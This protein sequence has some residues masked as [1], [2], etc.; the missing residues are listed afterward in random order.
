M[1]SQQII[2]E[3]LVTLGLDGAKFDKGMADAEKKQDKLRKAA[4]KWDK[5][6]RQNRDEEEREERKAN[7]RRE[8]D[9]SRTYKN[10]RRDALAF[11]SVFTAG[12][13][14]HNFFSDT[15]DSAANLGYLSQNLN[16]STQELSAW[17]MATQRAGGSAEGIVA[18]FK[19][20]ADTL[21]Q[22]RLGMGP[23]EG[24]QN[25]FR[26]GGSKDDLKDA[27]SYLLARSRIINQAFQTDPAKAALMA[28]QMGVF[29]DQFNFIKQGPDAVNSLVDA[30]KKNAVVTADAAE[31]ARQ[32]KNQWLDFT[33]TLE[34]STIKVL[35]AAVP[36]L[37]KFTE[38]LVELADK[39]ANNKD[40]I[41]NVIG[42]MSKFL[43]TTDWTAVINGAKEFGVEIKSIAT[44]LRDI[45]DR[46]DEWRG[47]PRVQTEGVTN[48]PGAVSFGKQDAM[49]ADLKAKGKAPAKAP[50]L[51]GWQKS[52]V[53]SL[54]KG[55]E[56]TVDTFK[57]L[58]KS[59]HP[60]IDA[61]T[62]G[63]LNK[64][65][66]EMASPTRAVDPKQAAYI[67]DRLRKYGW[68]NEQAAG[69]VGSL[70]Q[71]SNLDPRAVNS[72]GA[73]GIAQ[74]L[75][76]DRLKAFKD[77]YGKDLR[78]STLDEQID[79]MQ[80]E[81][82]QG[83]EK[84]AGARLKNARSAEEAAVIHRKYYERPGEDEANDERRKAIG[85]DLAKRA[86]AA[87]AAGAAAIPSGAAQSSNVTT[88]KTSSVSSTT[89][90]DK[91][92]INTAATDATAIAKTI[93]P[94]VEKFTFATNAISG[95]A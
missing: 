21:A 37:S 7:E 52:Y 35:I 29:E 70:A 56:N 9:A 53:D 4:Q 55:I 44:S 19:E 87:S 15:L 16:K 11:F 25:F 30:Q 90:I 13:A 65:L 2:D 88:N 68:T 80:Y 72:K 66:R 83:S 3:F 94:A 62:S 51:K 61:F 22:M 38:G 91:I 42:D 84:D 78:Q 85:A 47:K 59:D 36:A 39:V 54:E 17:Q 79:F 40:E 64:A 92:V 27:E 20:S 5:E 41:V 1:S 32:L 24:L 18:Q 23:N 10:M 73:F 33:Q 12:K 46:Y 43:A 50:E 67:M 77:K 69:M 58:K 75:S 8:Q 71:E 63:G 60:I 74:W 45:L 95:M 48:L 49:A 14:V 76:K 34:A 57:Q 82:T 86:R 89:S 81:L 26:F 6:R 93:A 28:R 31:K